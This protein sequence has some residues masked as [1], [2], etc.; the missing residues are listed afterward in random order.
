MPK[1]PKIYYGKTM[2]KYREKLD[3]LE[4]YC[5]K[6][7]DYFEWTSPKKLFEVQ[8]TSYSVEGKFHNNLVKVS[9]CDSCI[10]VRFYHTTKTSQKLLD[11]P[12]ADPN[13]KVLVEL[14]LKQIFDAFATE[15]FIVT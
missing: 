12:I 14:K 6:Y 15:D 8:S 1:L 13:G 11:V 4:D 2:L 5:G 10:T 7:S 3:I 9:L